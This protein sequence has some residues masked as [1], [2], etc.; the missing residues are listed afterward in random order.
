[1]H[2]VLSDP[3]SAALIAIAAICATLATVGLLR[4]TQQARFARRTAQGADRAL[5]RE[6]EALRTEIAA[7]IEQ[8]DG[9]VDR[10]NARLDAG[11]AAGGESANERARGHAAPAA[12][13][14]PQTG[15]LPGVE[16]CR[17]NL[18]RFAEST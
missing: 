4:R 6:Y 17:R 15:T 11:A 2:Q 9:V 18:R 3:A 12:S 16:E 1:M 13:P 7:L 14:E 5:L 10:L 8:L